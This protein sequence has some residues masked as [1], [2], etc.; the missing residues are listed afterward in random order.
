[1]TLMD[2]GFRW[3][4]RTALAAFLLIAA[5]PV[6]A[7]AQTTGTTAERAANAPSGAGSGETTA[8]EPSVATPGHALYV[9]AGFF[10]DSSEPTRFKDE[11]C[12][13]TSPPHLYGC[14]DG[15]DGAPLSSHGDFGTTGGID[16]GLGYVA[17]PALRVEALIQ[18][19][20]RVAF[21]GQA[22]FTQLQLTD[23]RDVSAELSTL[24]GILAAYVDLPA[25]GLSQLGPFTPFV[26]AG[27]GVSRIR[28]GETRQEFPRTRTIVPGGRRTGFA[29]MATAGLAVPLRKAM[30][31]DVAYRYTDYG[32]VTTGKATGRVEWRDGS[33]EPIVFPLARTEAKLR[34]HG[35]VVSL[36]YAF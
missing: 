12:T 7:L 16:L 22:N 27:A 25:L 3:H 17:T 34:R 26:G 24:T 6:P 8:A 35:W 14:G 33:R 19:H 20:P 2:R 29:W 10:L 28:I 1:M 31:L 36:R 5:A 11:D 9:R 30:T 21:K 4:L 13:S 18:H 32:T 23:R 15:I